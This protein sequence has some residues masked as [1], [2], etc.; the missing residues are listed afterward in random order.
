MKYVLALVAM[1]AFAASAVAQHSHGPQKGPN[2]G[3]M[4][5]VAGVHAELVAAGNTITINIFDEGNKPIATPGFTA[6]AL[7]VRGSERETLTLAPSGENALKA[8]SK[9]PIGPGTAVTVT[10]KTATGKSGQTR[11]KL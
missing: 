1:L 5:D 10:L 7:I 2:G 11:F 3:P 4:E 8:D 6:S 9:K